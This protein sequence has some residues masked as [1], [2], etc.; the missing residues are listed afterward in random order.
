MRKQHRLPT[1][2]TSLPD[3][4]ALDHSHRRRLPRASPTLTAQS[5]LPM[6]MQIFIAHQ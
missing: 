6:N 3:V 4:V 5:C 2:S 1:R